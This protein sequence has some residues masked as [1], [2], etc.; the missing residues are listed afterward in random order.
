MPP[1]L[2]AAYQLMF[3]HFRHHHWWPGETPF[4][5]CV[6][7][8]LTQ[9][10]NWQNVERAIENLRQGQALD[11]HTVAR[12]SHNSL[13]NMIRP[14]GYYNVKAKRLKA[15]A[16]QVMTRHAGSLDSLFQ[17]KTQAVRDELLTVKGI[18]PET[19][20]S[21][22]LYAGNH[23]SFVV[24]AY[25]KRI[26]TRHRWVSGRASYDEI[27]RLCETSL[28]HVP[29]SRRLDYWQDYH[30]QLVNIGKDY[31]RPGNPRCDLCPLKSLL[32]SDGQPYSDPQPRA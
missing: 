12:L 2:T 14:A 4:E 28:N 27:K 17:Q 25:T 22:L 15:F 16:S 29:N 6:G 5:I 18:G 24:D 3:N 32:P 21:I 26:F 11:L 7:T 20:D 1:P 13:A 30:A 8:I 19:A 9:N 23:A 10:T 31:C